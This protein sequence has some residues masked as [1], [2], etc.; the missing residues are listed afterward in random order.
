M[1]LDPTRT[2]SQ[3]HNTTNCFLKIYLNPLICRN[4]QTQVQRQPIPEGSGDNTAPKVCCNVEVHTQS[5]KTKL[6]KSVEFPEFHVNQFVYP[7][8][9]FA[10]LS[11]FLVWSQ[12]LRQF[13]YFAAHPVRGW[14]GWFQWARNQLRT[15]RS[16]SVFALLLLPAERLLVEEELPESGPNSL[17]ARHV[18][19]QLLDGIDLLL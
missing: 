1:R 14:N 13:L 6:P 12:Q 10:S 8:G 11:G 5:I 15:A 18:V 16:S 2:S 7:P 9:S 3:S 17:Q 19:G 4:I